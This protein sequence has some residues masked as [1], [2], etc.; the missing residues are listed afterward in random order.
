VNKFIALFLVFVFTGCVSLNGHAQDVI[1]TATVRIICPDKN[2]ALKL[3]AAWQKSKRAAMEAEKECHTLAYPIRVMK[4]YVVLDYFDVDGDFVELWRLK[5]NKEG[6]A[7][8]VREY[9]ED[10]PATPENTG[11]GV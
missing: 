3:T 1:E 7:I 9:A 11:M 6:Y 5:A 2:S 8:I 4:D 10:P